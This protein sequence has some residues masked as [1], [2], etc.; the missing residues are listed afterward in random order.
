MVHDT[1]QVSYDSDDYDEEASL[2]LLVDN[3]VENRDDS[4]VS[5]DDG[6]YRAFYVACI[7]DNLLCR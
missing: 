7:R 2:S 4:D 5:H 6:K 1:R 3:G